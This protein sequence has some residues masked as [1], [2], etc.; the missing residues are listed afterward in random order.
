MPKVLQSRKLWSAIV[1]LIAILV[2][3]WQSG[4]AL[5]PDTVVNAIMVIVS[6]Y[7][8]A[9]ALEDGMAK[10]NANT[11]TVSTPGTSDVVV[12]PTDAPTP[13]VSRTGLL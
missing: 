3:A 12:T 1:G 5:D 7:M 8:A 6:A 13:T 2:T 10:R 4:A 11:T 9:V